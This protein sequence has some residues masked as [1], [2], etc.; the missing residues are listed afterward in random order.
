MRVRERSPTHALL[1]L[2][3]QLSALVDSSN[4]SGIPVLSGQLKHLAG[5]ATDALPP[6]DHELCGQ[7]WHFLPAKPGKQAATRRWQMAWWRG[8]G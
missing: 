5:L 7:L 6:G 3:V 1:A 8:I 4:F 2:P